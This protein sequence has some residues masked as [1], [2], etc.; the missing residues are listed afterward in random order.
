MI[1]A[2]VDVNVF[3][4]GTTAIADKVVTSGGRVLVVSSF[5][6][7]VKEAVDRAYAAITQIKFEGMI[8]RG[9]IAHRYEG[10]LP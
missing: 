8:F 3:H 1:N 10:P 6:S 4:A 2:F 7:S 9:D 5:A